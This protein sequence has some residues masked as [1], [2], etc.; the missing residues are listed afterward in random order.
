MTLQKRLVT[1]LLLLTIAACSPE[2]PPTDSATSPTPGASTAP[3]PSLPAPVASNAT[4][5]AP[6][7]RCISVTSTGR[8]SNTGTSVAQCRGS[9]ADF[10]VPK[11]TLPTGFGGPWFQPEPIENATTNG[12]SATR[13]WMNFDP[14]VESQRLR[15]LLALRNYIF[16]SAQVRALTPELTADSRYRD[17]SAGGVASSLRQQKWYPAPRMFYGRPSDPG[18]REAAH[19]MT[20]ERSIAGGELAGNTQRFANYAVAYYDARGAHTYNE[21]WST[22]TPGVDTPDT[23]HMQFAEGSLVFKLL[24]SAAE[25]NDFPVDILDESVAANI[26]PNPGGEAVPVR[27]LQIDIAVKDNRAP[28]TGW[29][30]ATYAYDRNFNNTSPWRRMVPVGLMWGNDPDGTPI[31]ESW[32]NAGAPAYAL[33]H[34][35]VDGRLNGPVDNPASACMSCHSTAQAPAVAQMLPQGAC[36][37]PSFRTNWFRNLP[38]TQAFGRF[39]S[40]S[41]SCIT[42]PAPPTPVAAD[43]SLQLAST[44]SRALTSERFNPCTWDTA[45]PPAPAPP[46]ALSPGDATVYEVTRDP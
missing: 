11:N 41:G 30:F 23:S 6:G 16:T 36:N 33:D 35:G 32:I 12:P 2:S 43:Y 46:A 44:V 37:Q 10:I 14:T 4:G 42:T 26:Q 22:G 7:S 3:A 38:G 20:L 17:S 27:L 5:C 21:V 19:G 8:P 25:P 28:T 45:S 39:T 40:S 31:T 1:G 34:L 15:Y 18:T 13:P 29:Y 9:F 24:F